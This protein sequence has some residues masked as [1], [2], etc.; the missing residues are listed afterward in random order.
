MLLQEA[1]IHRLLE[2]EVQGILKGSVQT[3]VT[4]VG[5]FSNPFWQIA[6]GLAGTT[7]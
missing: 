3:W 1:I 2:V 5:G 4:H 7:F 6:V